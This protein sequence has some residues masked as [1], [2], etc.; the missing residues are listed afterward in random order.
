[1]TTTM[2]TMGDDDDDGMV[3]TMV[4]VWRVPVGRSVTGDVGDW[5]DDGNG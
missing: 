4:W 1:M 3:M 5:D 2:T